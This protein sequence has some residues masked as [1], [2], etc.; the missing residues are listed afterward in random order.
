[1][2]SRAPSF[3]DAILSYLPLLN[4]TLNGVFVSLVSRPLKKSSICII[5]KPP[6]KAMNPRAMIPKMIVKKVVRQPSSLLS[7]VL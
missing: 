6:T 1:M 4:G 3:G 2:G 5:M 7:D